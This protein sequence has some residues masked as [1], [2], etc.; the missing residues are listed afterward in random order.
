[1]TSDKWRRGVSIQFRCENNTKWEKENYYFFDNSSLYTVRSL[2]TF[3]TG[4]ARNF[5]WG[6]Q[7]GKKIATLF[8]DV[9]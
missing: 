6:A 2:R 4:V 8:A 1:M 5:D 9:F 7:I 3:V